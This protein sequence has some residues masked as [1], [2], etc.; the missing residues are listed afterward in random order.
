MTFDSI[1]FY[2]KTIRLRQIKVNSFTLEYDSQIVLI[3]QIVL[4][5]RI[6][7]PFIYQIIDLL[8]VNKRTEVRVGIENVL[9]EVGCIVFIWFDS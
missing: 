6:F 9:F 4:I 3:I 8:T 7:A 2:I 1:K 5:T